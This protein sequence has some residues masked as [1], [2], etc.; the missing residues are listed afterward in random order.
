MANLFKCEFG[1]VSAFVGKLA[2][3]GLTDEHVDATLKDASLVSVMVDALSAHLRGTAVIANGE[4]SYTVTLPAGK[5]LME[6]ITQGKYDSVSDS[7][8][9][10]NFPIERKEAS[11]ELEVILV[12]FD[13]RL[14][15]K[16]VEAE[17][18]RRDLKPAKIDALLALG[19]AQPEL[20]RKFP[21]VAFRGGDLSS[22]YLDYDGLKRFLTLRW[23]DGGDGWNNHWRFLAVRK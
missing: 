11:Q 7:I 8:T 2:E 15:T 6:L 16:Q 22:F 3:A 21:I 18:D 19:S 1:R 23:F 17:L 4:T 13:K 20:Q 12:H 5:A 10:A 14:S 9:E